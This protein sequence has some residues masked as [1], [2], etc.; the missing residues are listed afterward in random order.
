MQDAVGEVFQ[1]TY[2]KAAHRQACDASAT[3]PHKI[4]SCNESAHTSS[5]NGMALLHSQHTDAHAPLPQLNSLRP[6]SWGISNPQR[7]F[8]LP[9]SAPYSSVESPQTV[10]QPQAHTVEKNAAPVHCATC[11]EDTSDP[12]PLFKHT[13]SASNDAEQQRQHTQTDT[14]PQAAQAATHDTMPCQASLQLHIAVY[15]LDEK[16]FIGRPEFLES[17]RLIS[18]QN[19]VYVPVPKRTHS[20]QAV[21]HKHEV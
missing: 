8:A 7:V 4:T 14:Q 18:L 2:Q 3:I 1:L 6:N 16:R 9:T 19:N 12:W 20:C 17:N 11:F 13:S 15:R 10:C 5:V 21:R